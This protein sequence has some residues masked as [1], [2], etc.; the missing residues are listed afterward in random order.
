AE[1]VERFAALLPRLTLGLAKL[2]GALGVDGERALV[3]GDEVQLLGGASRDQPVSEVARDRLGIALERIAVAPAG[4]LADH[5]ELALLHDLEL[6]AH[7]MRRVL[8]ALEW[9]IVHQ[10]G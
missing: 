6:H 4:A 10:P 2:L 3:I 9:L 7:V 1:P 8:R 5:V